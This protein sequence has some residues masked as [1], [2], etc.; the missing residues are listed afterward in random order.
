VRVR[1]Q[2]EELHIEVEDRGIGIAAAEL[3]R[4]FERFYRSPRTGPVKGVGLGL[5]ICKRFVEAHGGSI[6]VASLEHHGT[7][8]TCVLPLDSG[9]HSAEVQD[10]RV[11][12]ASSRR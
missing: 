12:T 3:E 2:A 10:D 11:R 8:V 7:T 6:A 1:R 9:D 4:I 5:S